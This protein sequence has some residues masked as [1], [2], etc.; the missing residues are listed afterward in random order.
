MN[1]REAERA[2]YDGAWQIPDYSKFSPGEKYADLFGEIAAPKAGETCIDLGCGAGAGGKALAQK[3]GLEVTYVDH[4]KVGDPPGRLIV[5]PL[6][7]P[8]PAFAAYGYC[9]DVMEHIPP[10]FTM[11]AVRN[12]LASCKAGVFF[13]ISFSHDSFGVYLRQPLHLTVEPFA[14]WKDRLGE[15]GTVIEARDL[16]GEGVFYV[17]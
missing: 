10:E 2:K 9:C 12:A 17:K 6:W 4:V 11:L 7:K 1:I 16:L 8:I 15:V 3:W 13:S 5:Q 14:W